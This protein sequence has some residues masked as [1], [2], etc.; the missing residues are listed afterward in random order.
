MEKTS[1][2]SFRGNS[3]LGCCPASVNVAPSCGTATP[4]CPAVTRRLCNSRAHR[5]EWL[6]HKT[7]CFLQMG[8]LAYDRGQIRN[9][10]FHRCGKLEE[11][12]QSDC[13][14]HAR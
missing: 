14:L 12:W 7:L 2:A 4:G 3:I 8:G 9:W 11:L 5:Q 13:G 1:S 10:R 6:P